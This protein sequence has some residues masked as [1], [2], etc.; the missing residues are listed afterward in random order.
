MDRPTFE[1]GLTR[2]GFEIVTNAMKP[3]AVNAEHAH[4][5]DARLLVVEGAMT[6]VRD[7]APIRTYAVGETF[8]MPAGTRHSEAAGEAGATYVA[9]RRAPV[10]H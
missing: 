7:G 2:E 8:E 1:A 5:F 3:N 6:I 4:S 10:E 9:G